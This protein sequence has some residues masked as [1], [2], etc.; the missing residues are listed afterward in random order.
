MAGSSLPWTAQGE[1]EQSLIVESFGEPSWANGSAV[2]G[3]PPLR[4][5]VVRPERTVEERRVHTPCHF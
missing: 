1:G 4:E 3:A 2:R 5:E